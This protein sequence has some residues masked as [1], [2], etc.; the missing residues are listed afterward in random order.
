MIDW[1]GT[2]K[3][4]NRDN[5]TNFIARKEFLSVLYKKYPSTFKMEK[6]IYVSHSAIWRAM[7][8]DGIEILPK[9]HRLHSLEKESL[10]QIKQRR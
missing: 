5:K 4:Y 8:K 2:I 10:W 7:K 9:G 3:A 1:E 6:I